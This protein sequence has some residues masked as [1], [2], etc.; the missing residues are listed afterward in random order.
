MSEQ[1]ERFAE[2]MGSVL[3]SPEPASPTLEQRVLAQLAVPAA[4]AVDSPSRRTTTRWW[5]RR[6][7]VTLTPARGL[8]LAAGLLL[9]VMLGPSRSPSASGVESVVAADTVHLV[10][11]VLV[12]P[13]ATRV[14]LVGDFNGW[15][16]DGVALTPTAE[17][18]V[19]SVSLPLAA[20]RYEYAF[21]VDGAQWVAD[22][23]LPVI[24]D[25]FGGEHSVLRLGS[26]RVM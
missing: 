1:D 7:T 21:V 3:R 11:F 13:S 10:R 23:A 16:V 26:S 22:P 20:G 19:W 25:E 14:A 2:R 18:G 4:H 6:W 9:M 24:R 8:A 17:S 12:N 15:A 5:D